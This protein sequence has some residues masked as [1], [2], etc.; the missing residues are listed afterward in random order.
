MKWEPRRRDNNVRIVRRIQL[1]ARFETTNVTH[2]HT[3][4]SHLA[5]IKSATHLADLYI[6]R[7]AHTH[8]LAGKTRPITTLPCV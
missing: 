8:V 2:A 3:L 4:Y 5:S 7:K 1:S 6:Y